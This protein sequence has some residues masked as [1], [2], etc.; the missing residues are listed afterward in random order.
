MRILKYIVLMLLL[1]APVS[2]IQSC[3]TSNTGNRERQIQREKKKRTRNDTVLYQKA[4]KQHMKSQ[5]KNTRKSMRQALHK[6][7]S[8]NDNKRE[9]FLTRWFHNWF[10]Y[11]PEQNNK[12]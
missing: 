8:Y 7:R 6:S 5:T 11:K 9:F 12:G 2:T 3:K 4:L 10:K 1:L